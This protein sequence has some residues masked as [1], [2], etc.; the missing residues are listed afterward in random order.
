[1]SVKIN[2]VKGFLFGFLAGGTVGAIATLLTASKSGKEFRG[3][4]KQKSEEYFDEADRYF[5]EKKNKVGEMISEGKRKYSMI[6]NDIKSKPE[7]I[8]KDAERV[9]KDA[10]LKSKDESRK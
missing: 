2:S 1:M 7:V 10:K 6:T 9:F 3:D 4:I 5:T 8:L